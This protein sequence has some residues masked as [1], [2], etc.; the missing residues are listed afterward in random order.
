MR[1]MIR[2]SSF[3]AILWLLAIALL[4]VRLANA[5]LHLCL[6]G[7]QQSVSL[8]VQDQPEH[9]DGHTDE[10]HNDRDVD[11]SKASSI[12][13]LPG[14][15]DDG[16]LAVINVYLLALLLPVQEAVVPSWKI[17]PPELAAHFPIRPPV[18][19]PPL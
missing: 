6:D 12:V 19:G 3:A 2:K 10:G 17:L 14:A 15:G 8:H 16:S 11:L 9:A 7:Q 5:H 4:P 1:P 13:K 18:R